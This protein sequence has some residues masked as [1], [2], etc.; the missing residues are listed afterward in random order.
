MTKPIH[1]L[2]LAS[3]MALAANMGLAEVTLSISSDNNQQTLDALNALTA[4]YTAAHPLDEGY[5]TRKDLYNLYHIL[6][7]FNLFGGGY[8]SQAERMIDR[9][10][11]EVC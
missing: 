9:L 4:A 3:A 5:A 1:S 10:L 6:N 11:A 2:A 8:G 7:H